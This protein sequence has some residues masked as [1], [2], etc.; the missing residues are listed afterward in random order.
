MKIFAMRKQA[1]LA[2][3]TLA[4]VAGVSVLAAPA[5]AASARCVLTI[6]DYDHGY[7]WRVNN[8]CTPARPSDRLIQSVYWGAD[9]P[10]VDDYLF[11]RR[12]PTMNDIFT[13]GRAFLDEDTAGS[14]EVYTENR[15]QRI[16]GTIYTVKS[17]EVH[18][19]FWSKF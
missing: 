16:D 8:N 19:Q 1:T 2:V 13:Q 6:T 9:W 14:D 5:Q 17:N 11:E 15:F 3:L 18:K 12:Y 4:T 7:V 10:D